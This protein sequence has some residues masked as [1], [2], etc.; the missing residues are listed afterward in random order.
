MK[1]IKIFI[2]NEKIEIR[3]LKLLFLKKNSIMKYFIIK[4]FFIFY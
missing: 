3:I 4:S 1:K 2:N